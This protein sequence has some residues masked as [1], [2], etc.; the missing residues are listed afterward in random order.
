MG[1]VA[2]ISCGN[3]CYLVTR[4]GQ[5][6]QRTDVGICTRGRL[7]V[8]ETAVEYPLGAIDSDLL[9]RIEVITPLVVSLP[10]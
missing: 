5:R 10:R 4:L 1:Y 2:P 6:L 7:Y 9:D 3:G 8:R